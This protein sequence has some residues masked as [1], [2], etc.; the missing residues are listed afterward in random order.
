MIADGSPDDILNA[1]DAAAERIETPCGEGRMVWRAWGSG[2][3]LVLLH[4]GYGS[5]RHWVRNIPHF[6]STHRVFAPDTPGLGDSDEAP[7]ATP[8]GI[9]AVVAQG[10]AQ[11]FAPDDE[12]DLVGFSFGALVAG[13][14]AAQFPRELASLTLVGPGA[15]G[16]TRANVMLN[17]S[18]VPMTEVERRD[19]NRANLAMLMIAD[20][21]K[22]DDLAIAIQEHNVGLARVKSRRFANSPSLAQALRQSRPARLNA[23]WG[24]KDAAADGYFAEREALLRDIRADVSFNLIPNAGHWVAYEAPEAFNHLLHTLLGQAPA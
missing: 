4:G 9:G 11:I 10:L 12:I 16:V 14:T 20:P 19:V 23:I 13:H 24:D 5:W 17:R 18:D 7:E 2:P 21:A 3:P 6:Q 15:L 22:I 8:E 1:L